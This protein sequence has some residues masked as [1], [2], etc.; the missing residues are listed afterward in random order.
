MTRCQ[1]KFND[2][3]KYE[4]VKEANK[5]RKAEQRKREKE[6]RVPSSA[7]SES[8][9]AIDSDVSSS[10]PGRFVTPS[11]S[12]QYLEGMKRKKKNDKVKHAKLKK[13]DSSNEDLRN[14]LGLS[15][16]KLKLKIA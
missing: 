5:R 15:S 13:L 14:K 3:E 12:R 11:P 2:P 6:N 1:L 10:Q 7:D 8:G 4:S 9:P 16:A